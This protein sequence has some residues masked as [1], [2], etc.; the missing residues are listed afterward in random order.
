M[1]ETAVEARDIISLSKHEGFLAKQLYVVFS[2]AVSG[3]KPVMDNL[4]AHLAF[5][6]ELEKDGISSRPAQT[7]PMTRNRGK[8]TVWSWFVPNHSPRQMKSRRA[9]RCIKAVRESSRSV[10]GSSTKGRFWCG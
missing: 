7:G 9:I 10:R 6:I 8:V 2:T 4:K 3:V 5:Q 1:S